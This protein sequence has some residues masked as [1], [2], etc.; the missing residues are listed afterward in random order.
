MAINNK[1]SL[2]NVLTIISLVVFLLVTH[3]TTNAQL[4]ELLAKHEIRIEKA[5]EDI[6]QHKS[7][8]SILYQTKA[9]KK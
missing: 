7:D 4:V 8:I 9:D 1:I 5:E 3:F 6:R 2:G